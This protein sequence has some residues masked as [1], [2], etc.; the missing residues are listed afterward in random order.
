MASID[1][2][3]R[4]SRRRSVPTATGSPS[5]TP[6]SAAVAALIRAQRRLRGAGQVLVAVLHPAGV[7]QLGPGGQQRLAGARRGR[8]AAADGRTRRH[9]STV[10]AQ[11]SSSARAASTVG[12]PRSTSSSSASAFE[13]PA[14]G[15]RA[16]AGDRQVERTAPALPGDVAAGLL[17][18]RRHRQHDVGVL[19]DRAA[20][21]LEA[22][23]EPGALAAPRRPSAGS[24]RSAGSTPPT[25]SAASAPSAAACRIAS[26]VAAG[27]RRQVGAPHR[28]RPRRARRRRRPGGRRAAGWAAR[29]RRPHRARRRG[30]APRPARRRCASARAAAALSAPGEVA[31]RSPTRISAPSA[32]QR[33]R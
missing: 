28:A 8:P 10:D 26:S 32:A 33:A 16:G 19:G 25:T 5:A 1:D 30:A 21:D 9:A 20:P 24:A 22:D 7:E 27:L 11:R 12:R 13:H 4:P 17:G 14:V 6:S 15:H 31:S 3:Q 23:H 29:R 18:G 2:R